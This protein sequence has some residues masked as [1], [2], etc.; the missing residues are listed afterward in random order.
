[1]TG[2]YLGARLLSRIP[3]LRLKVAVAVVLGVVGVKELL[4]P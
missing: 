1:V 3:E 2:A 4:F